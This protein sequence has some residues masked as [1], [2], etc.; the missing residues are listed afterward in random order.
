MA[1]G[2]QAGAALGTHTHHATTMPL[3]LNTGVTVAPLSTGMVAGVL[4]TAMGPIVNN[5]GEGNGVAPLDMDTTNHHPD[6][7]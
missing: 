2:T 4:N 7:R 5:L 3:M 1:P 6:H